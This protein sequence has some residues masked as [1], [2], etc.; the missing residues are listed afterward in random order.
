M[1]ALNERIL[2]IYLCAWLFSHVL[3]CVTPWTIA[4]QAPLSMEF[5]RQEYWSG[6]PCPLPG[7]F[8]NAGTEPRSPSL[9]ADSLLP[10]PP[11]KHWANCKCSRKMK[12]HHPL[13][14]EWLLLL[15]SSRKP[16]TNWEM[17]TND[18]DLLTQKFCDSS[19]DMFPRLRYQKLMF[20]QW[21]PSEGNILWRLWP[22][23]LHC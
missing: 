8:L 11:G 2:A 1:V 16:F 6:L 17:K 5:S 9:Q 22:M 15:T 10:E 18:L 4:R 21:C 7:D 12:Y 13:T 14:V 23:L 19:A 3:L 20:H